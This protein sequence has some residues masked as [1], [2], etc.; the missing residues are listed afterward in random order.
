[1]VAHTDGRTFPHDVENKANV[2]EDKRGN[3][4]VTH[5]ELLECGY[6]DLNDFD[7]VYLNGKFYELQ[8]HIAKPDAWWIEEVPIGEETS[9]TEPEAQEVA[10]GE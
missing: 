4:Y 3:L 5:T 7:V 1:M 10:E 6:I 9:E 2:Y 8:G